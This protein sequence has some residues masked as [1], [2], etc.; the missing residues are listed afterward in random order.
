M[1]NRALSSRSTSVRTSCETSRQ[2]H[3]H[4]VEEKLHAN[5]PENGLYRTDINQYMV[6]LDRWQAKSWLDRTQIIKATSNIHLIFKALVKKLAKEHMKN[7]WLH[8]NKIHTK[9]GARRTLIEVDM[10]VT[11]WGIASMLPILI[12]WWINNFFSFMLVQLITN[13]VCRQN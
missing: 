5:R 2:R 1:R 7:F 12:F 3:E 10:Y 4:Q 8:A 9:G 6:P 13:I 11:T